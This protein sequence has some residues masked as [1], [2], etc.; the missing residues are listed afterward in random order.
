MARGWKFGLVG[1]V[2]LLA[3]CA[4]GAGVFSG[5]GGSSNIYAGLSPVELKDCNIAAAE[6]VGNADWS[7]VKTIKINIRNELFTP[8]VLRLQPNQPYRIRFVNAD[9]WFRSFQAEEFFAAS[10]VRRM[11]FGNEEVAATCTPTITIGANSTAEIDILP[12]KEGHYRWAENPAM[13]DF[14]WARGKA[15]GA[16][17][18]R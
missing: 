4:N 9:N 14:V 18:V 6:R 2:L 15:T 16:I 7:K 3:G 5:I 1:G 13:F 8:S 12:V 17:V 10:A 11:K